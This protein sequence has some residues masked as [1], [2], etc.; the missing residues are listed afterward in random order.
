MTSLH[1]AGQTDVGRHRKDNQDTFVS[2]PLWS[3]SDAL[4][5]VIDG[6]G[7]YAGGA[8]A[9][10]LA[11][12][13]IVQYMAAPTGN[14]LSMLREAVVHANN[15]IIRQKKQEPAL[16]HMCCVLTAV[17][18][19]ANAR[20]LQ[21]VHVGDTRLYR[22][23][24]QQLEKL[25]RDHSL[26]GVREDANQLTEYEAMNH[27]RRNEIL[28]DVGSVT[29]R[30]DDADF[31]E[32]GETDFLPGDVL[33]LCSD[34]LTDMLTRAELTDVLTRPMP[35]DE[36]ITELI[37]QANEQGGHDNI[38]VVLAHYPVSTDASVAESQP[39][40]SSASVRKPTPAHELMPALTPV[41]E[42]P[43]SR[44]ELPQTRSPV[45][46]LLLLLSA[47]VL[48]GVLWWQYEPSETIPAPRRVIPA[49]SSVTSNR[50][51]PDSILRTP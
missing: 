10:A 25:T 51:Q 14:T 16:A 42:Q 49:D 45:R 29:H 31:L 22:F 37:R 33:V 39:P 34:G 15:Q 11:Q 6:V 35:V 26:V 38:T 8:Q 24:A 46:T 13:S 41:T 7:G 21:Y 2:Q 44:P 28:R 20:R 19:D 23:R 32:S 43:E 48:A 50:A 30:V 1:I 4:L 40:A 3:A 17:V 27:P 5:V 9:A 18:V 12:E 36:Q 47:G